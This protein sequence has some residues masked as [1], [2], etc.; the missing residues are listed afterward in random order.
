MQERVDE[1]EDGIGVQASTNAEELTESREI[2]S[3]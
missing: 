2:T 1:S 3:T